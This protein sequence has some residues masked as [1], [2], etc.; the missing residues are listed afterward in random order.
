[1]ANLANKYKLGIF[2]TATLIVFI[3][4]LFFLGIFTFLKPKIKCVTIV[5]SS[6]QG[7]SVGA[8]VKFN[9]VPIGKITA[10]KIAHGNYIYVYMDIFTESLILDDN[11]KGESFSFRDYINEEIKKGLGCQ[12]K[13]EGITGTLYQEIQ[14]FKPKEYSKDAIPSPGGRLLYIPSVPPVLFGNIMKRIDISLNKIS[15]IDEIFAKVND[16]LKKINQYLE[17]PKIDSAID[18]VQKITKDIHG[19][20]DNFKDILTKEKIEQI[21]SE[22]SKTMK[23][24]S[25]VVINVNKLLKESRIPETAKHLNTAIHNFNTTAKGIKS[26]TDQLD[27]NPSAIIWGNNKKKVVPSY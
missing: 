18:N 25:Q 24:I 4:S 10:I 16:A 19:I 14:Y 12:L 3:V 2:V 17:D 8:K 1:M 27:N 26:L 20:T 5:K 21:T 11:K 7:L 22:L 6:V 9:G 13:Y 23:D 15:G